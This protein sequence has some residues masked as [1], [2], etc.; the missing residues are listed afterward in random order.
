MKKFTLIAVVLFFAKA[1]S[2]QMVVDAEMFKNNPSMFMGKVITINNVIYKSKSSAPGAPAGGVVT[3]PPA[4][5]STPGA[6]A[7]G[8]GPGP[9]SPKSVYCNPAPGFTLTTWT[10]GPNNDLCLQVDSKV[11]P[12]VDQCP[13]GSTVKSI[14][15]RCTPNMFVA[16]RVTK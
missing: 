15:F 4:K 11:M 10:L 7:G 16:V 6:P 9:G 8:V 2:A 1:L 13:V 14:T 5:P 3:P 12:M